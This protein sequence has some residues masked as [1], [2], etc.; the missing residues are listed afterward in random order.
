MQRPWFDGSHWQLDRA[1]VRKLDGQAG[2]RKGDGGL[3][4]DK[5]GV[6]PGDWEKYDGRAT[7]S[8]RLGV[9]QAKVE[10]QGRW[11]GDGDGEV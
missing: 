2:N 11:D 8:G 4:E 7:T 6:E 1:L 5:K 10:A 9:H 3:P